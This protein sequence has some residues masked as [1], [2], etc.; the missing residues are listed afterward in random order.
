MELLHCIDGLHEEDK[1]VLVGLKHSDDASVYKLGKFALVQT[2]DFITPI[3]DDPYTFGQIA[4]A[5]SLSDVFA[6]NGK[7]LNAL[8]IV[9]YDNC[10]LNT[11][12]LKEILQGGCSKVKESGGL[13]LGGHSIQS[14]EMFYGLSVTGKVKEKNIYKNNTPK[15][16]DVLILTK[17]LGTGI[18]ST[19]IK[20]R[21]ANKKDEKRICTS[22][23]RLNLYAQKILKKFDISACTD[24]SGFGLLGHAKEMAN[25][26]VTLAFNQSD[27]CFFDN[28]LKYSKEGLIPE[29]TYKNYEFIK[30]ALNIQDI[31]LA[32]CDAQTS[33]GLLVAINEKQ[34][35][36]ALRQIQE[37]GDEQARIVGKVY[38]RK[39]YSLKII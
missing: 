38:P 11:K 27:I 35:T 12:I 32:L 2:L 39:Q 10:N 14:S 36:K 7:V 18:I 13:I 3:V 24:I 16:G 21:V 1:R 5:N 29:G 4:A 28:V 19:A 30:N 37:N 22:M 9:G 23:T 26:S 6:M 20:A 33:G 31:N 8:N 34:A 25:K 17:P 15:V